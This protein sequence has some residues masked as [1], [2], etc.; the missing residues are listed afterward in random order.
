MLSFPVLKQKFSE[1][2]QLPVEERTS[3]QRKDMVRELQNSVE[4]KEVDLSPDQFR[5][6]LR[7]NYVLARILAYLLQEYGTVSSKFEDWQRNVEE[8][9]ERLRREPFSQPTTTMPLYYSVRTFLVRLK[10]SPDSIKRSKL[11]VTRFEQIKTHLLERNLDGGG[12]V[13]GRIDELL[14]IIQGKSI[15]LADSAVKAAVS[16]YRAVIL[17]ALPIEFNAVNAHLMD[18]RE[19]VHKQGTVYHI[20]RFAAEDRNWEVLLLEVGAGNDDA[21]LETERAISY[22]EPDIAL[23][24]GVA[25]GIKDVRVGDVVAATKIYGYESGRAESV[26]RPRPD[27]GQS[28]HAM[29]HR[30]RTEANKSRWIN[31]I[32]GGATTNPHVFVGPIAAGEKVVGS[33]ESEVY[34]F[35]RESYSDALAVE[36]EGRGFLTATHANQ[37]KA[38]VVRGISDTLNNKRDLDDAARQRLASI[39]ASAFAFE[40]IAQ[41]KPLKSAHSTGENL[42]TEELRSGDALNQVDSSV[43]RQLVEAAGAYG[44]IR[45]SMPSGNE[46]TERMQEIV[47]KKIG[48]LAISGYPLLKEFSESWSSGDVLVAVVMLQ[49]QPNPNYIR[50]LGARMPLPE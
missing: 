7:N 9:W 15:P 45:G 41:L 20:G 38:L 27:V 42:A 36:M 46:R 37:V 43:R 22:F 19:E 34:K 12:H 17:T 30:S 32:I 3:E 8:E 47:E 28:S 2:S 14:S 16:T 5:E 35:I 44:R 48:P 11:D 50:W 26:F 4:N 33:T 13:R 6:C 40:V 21:A 23:F 24:V 25:G 29:V 10:E 1:F 18:S 31:R 39:H 49:V